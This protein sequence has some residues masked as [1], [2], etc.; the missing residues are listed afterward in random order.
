MGRYTGPVCKLCRA[1]GAKL[2]LKGARC[3]SA[4]CAMNNEKHAHP[5]GQHGQGRKKVSDYGQQ[6]RAKQKVR[7]YYSVYERQ[8]RRYFVAATRMRGVTGEGMLQLLETRLDNVVFRSGLVSSR[9]EARQLV[10]H[11]HFQIDGKVVN[12]PSF[13]VK[14][15][16]VI[17][18]RGKSKG[19]DV[20]QAGGSIRRTPAWMNVDTDGK[21][22]TVVSVPSR[23]E[24]ELP[25]MTESLIVEFYSR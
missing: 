15:G 21:R 8:F 10:N 13:C 22:I 14:P 3:I 5:P 2:F 19:K 11:R 7:R 16:M 17:E 4:K 25:E 1:E 24:M 9:A 20:F 18:V 6:L 12:I 23:Q